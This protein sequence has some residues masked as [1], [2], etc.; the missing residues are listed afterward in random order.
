MSVQ[1][2]LCAYIKE[3]FDIGDDPDFTVDLHLFDEGYV[4]SLAAVQIISFAEE[5]WDI[6]ITQRDLV[7]Y[8]MNTVAEIA[9]VVEN[10][11]KA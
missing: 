4:D 10:H 8:P 6:E 7:L 11:R 1:E 5:R 3:T 2:E 9:F